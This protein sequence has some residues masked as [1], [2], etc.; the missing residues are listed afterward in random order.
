MVIALHDSYFRTAWSCLC[1][2]VVGVDSERGSSRRRLPAIWHYLII[3]RSAVAV[4]CFLKLSRRFLTCAALV[5][6][7]M[8][9]IGDAG[10]SAAERFR[11]LFTR[12]GKFQSTIPYF[13]MRSG[14]VDCLDTDADA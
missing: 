4:F 14:N 11:I 10:S 8:S 13:I 7:N 12:N 3:R 6:R 1:V 5:A 9:R 2:C